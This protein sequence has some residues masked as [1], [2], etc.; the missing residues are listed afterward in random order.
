MKPQVRHIQKKEQKQQAKKSV[1]I[2]KKK[3]VKPVS[4]SELLPQI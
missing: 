3:K 1:T 4:K 2:P